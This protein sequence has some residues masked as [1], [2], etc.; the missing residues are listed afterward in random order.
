MKEKALT[1]E[2]QLGHGAAV[3]RDNLRFDTNRAHV[4][5]HEKQTRVEQ[6]I[7]AIDRLNSIINNMERAMLALKSK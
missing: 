3:E 4:M 6:Q 7:V 2:R 1:Q 5:Y